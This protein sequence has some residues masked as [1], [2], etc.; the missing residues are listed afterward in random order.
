MQKVQEVD[1]NYEPGIAH[2]V[3]YLCPDQFCWVYLTSI[4]VLWFQPRS[5]YSTIVFWRFLA[6]S[7]NQFL[8]E[9]YGIFL[10]ICNNIEWPISCEWG[11]WHM[12]IGPPVSCNVPPVL[13]D[14][15]RVGLAHKHTAGSQQKLNISCALRENVQSTTSYIIY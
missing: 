9:T 1:N 11:A 4:Y 5:T 7:K 14:V 6:V 15:H 10:V 3:E 12:W 2:Q 8:M 13:F